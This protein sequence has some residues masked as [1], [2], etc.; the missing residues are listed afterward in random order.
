MVFRQNV[1]PRPYGG[2]QERIPST[3]PSRS[4]AFLVTPPGG[5]LHSSPSPARSP[6]LRPRRCWAH[7]RHYSPPPRTWRRPRRPSRNWRRQA[8]RPRRPSPHAAPPLVD[9]LPA[10][11]ALLPLPRRRPRRGRRRP[12]AAVGTEATEV[13][14]G[15]IGDSS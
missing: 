3:Y 14:F 8:R 2:L 5:H 11:K 13:L 1:Y 6:V 4:A 10:S 12:P 7:R 9:G 15:V